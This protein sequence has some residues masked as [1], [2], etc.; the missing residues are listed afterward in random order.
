MKKLFFIFLLLATSISGCVL[1]FSPPPIST[2]EQNQAPT[3]PPVV[4]MATPTLTPLSPSTPTPSVLSID[5]LRNATLEIT[6]SDNIHRTITLKDG[7]YQQGT[8]SSQAG[9]ITVSLGEKIALGDLNHDGLEDAALTL[10]ENFGGSGSFV[11]LIAVI[12]Q[13]GIPS[14]AASRL[15]DDRPI[16]NNLSIQNEKI[17]LSATIHGI[18]DPMC[19]PTFETTQY[20]ELAGE[21]LVMQQFSSKSF[22][23]TE[24]VITIDS[25]AN[26]SEISAPFML[27]GSI[28]VSPFENNL[29]CLIYPE[30][31]SEPT[32]QF[33]IDV[34]AADFGAPGTFEVSLDPATLNLK[35]RIRIEIADFSAAD[36]RYLASNSVTVLL[37]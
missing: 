22:S 14:A 20:Y 31:A 7:K 24:E 30:G 9:Y 17:T 26:G 19:C 5:S 29:G 6:G 32:Q 13:N 33:G 11:S 23:G 3:S 2:Q 18:Q 1:D 37:K 4:I 10:V 16:I 25:P 12:N 28:T 36:G 27:K 15:I 35:G 34:S 8:D 21:K